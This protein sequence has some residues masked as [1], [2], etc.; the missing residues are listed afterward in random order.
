[1]ETA[2]EKTAVSQEQIEDVS[3]ENSRQPEPHS[4]DTF[5][6]AKAKLDRAKNVLMQTDEEV[7]EC[8]K[9]IED[10]LA[11]FKQ[12]HEELLNKSIRPV[13][14]LMTEMGLDE[15]TVTEP[16]TLP[17]LEANDP[18]I[19]PVEVPTISRGTFGALMI[20]LGG[21][22][23]A[24]GAW[25]FAATQALGLPILPSK[26]P[27]PDR[28]NQA[29][30]WTAEQ[31]GQ[32]SNV[33][34]GGAVVGVGALLIGGLLYW[35]TKA[36][37]SSKNI[38]IAR[39]VEEETEFYCT[40]KGECKQQMEKIREHI[41]HAKKT[42]ESY[43]VLLDE[44][45]AKLARARHIEEADSFDALHAKTRRDI[46]KAKHLIDEVST[47]LQTPMAQSGILNH[48]GIKAL[49]KAANEANKYVME[50]YQ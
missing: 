31:L 39:K 32:G 44:L 23:L 22:V 15:R 10:D 4:T 13:R 30:A 24:L 18:S 41:A 48:E 37:R 36:L 21:T 5:T 25:C 26:F 49:E 8:L 34:V 7:E 46:E 27:D 50:L 43:T 14:H 35:V 19:A 33:A 3:T 9:K 29:L 6:V 38:K 17:E 40:K 16:E 45:R 20:G 47:F 12:A 11:Q 2:E 1:M 42:V 28:L